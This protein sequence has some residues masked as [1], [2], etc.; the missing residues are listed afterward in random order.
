MKLTFTAFL[1]FITA[2]CFAQTIPLNRT[3]NWTNSGYQGNYL[4]N[5]TVIDFLTVGG[6]ADGLTDNSV[7][8][9]NA[10]ANAPK[11]V[12]IYF[13]GGN[14]LFNSSINLPDSTILRGATSDST[15]LLFDFSGAIGNG[16]NISGTTGPTFTNVT[17]GAER[18]SNSIVVDDATLFSVGDYAEIMQ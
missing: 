2:S 14:Y 12:V 17:S 18:F 6:V 5:A 16:I 8:L 3:F 13:P 1:F 9:Q 10:I 15:N 11:P 4:R 7:A